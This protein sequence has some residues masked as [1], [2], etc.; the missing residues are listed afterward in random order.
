MTD[1][2]KN[3]LVDAGWAT[4][5]LDDPSIR[6]VEVDVDTTAYD[7]GHIPGAVAWSCSA[8]SATTGT[9]KSQSR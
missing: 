9:V 4:G 6:F 3:V 5:R 2:A 7:E 8:T 1:Y